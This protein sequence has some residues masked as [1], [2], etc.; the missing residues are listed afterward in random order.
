MI[1]IP[2]RIP[3]A[4]GLLCLVAL[5]MDLSALVAASAPPEWPRV[6]YRDGVTNTIYQPQL[7][8]WDYVTIKAISAVAVQPKG[9]RQSTFGSIQ[10][11]AKTRV[12]RARREVGF[13]ELQIVQGDFPSA[14]AKAENY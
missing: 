10:I 11:R 5:M 1:T 14:G 8:S 6:I 3:V 4:V 7:Q 13:E 12:D 2:R 9:A